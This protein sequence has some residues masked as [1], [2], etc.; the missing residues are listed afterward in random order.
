MVAMQSLN[1]LPVLRD[2]VITNHAVGVLREREVDDVEIGDGEGEEV[3]EEVALEIGGLALRARVEDQ[4]G[5]GHGGGR[6]RRDERTVAERLLQRQGLEGGA[7]EKDAGGYHEGEQ[8]QRAREIALRGFRGHGDAHGGRCGA[9]R[10]RRMH[11][12]WET[13]VKA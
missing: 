3:G 8:Q 7:R 11:G 13:C 1:N 2:V 4:R 5:G 9:G 6:R 10:L 12:R